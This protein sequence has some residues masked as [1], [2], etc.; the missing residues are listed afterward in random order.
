MK[1]YEISEMTDEEILKRIEE[2]ETNLVDL[3]FQHELK[4]LTNTAK[5]NTVRKDI[6]RLKTVLRERNL[7]AT[8]EQKEN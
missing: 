4:N 1:M 6:A 8:L 2:E 5:L 3:R 7:K